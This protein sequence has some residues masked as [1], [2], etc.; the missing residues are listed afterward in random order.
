MFE[1]LKV[2]DRVGFIY[3][4]KAG[5]KWQFG[6]VLPCYPKQPT[7]PAVGQARTNQLSSGTG[8]RFEPFLRVLVKWSG[9]EVSRCF[10]TV[11]IVSG[12]FTST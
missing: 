10:N 1:T 3:P 7:S 6:V 5:P 12:T 9:K 2:G 8:E 11:K 4:T